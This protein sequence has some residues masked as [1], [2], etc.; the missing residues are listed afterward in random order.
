MIRKQIQ[1]AV[2]YINVIKATGS[3]F[4]PYGKVVEMSIEQSLE[5]IA[6]ATEELLALAKTQSDAPAKRGRPTK[7]KEAEVTDDILGNESAPAYTKDDVLKALR[8][9]M[10]KNGGEKTKE[11][12]I[13]HGADKAKPVLTTI[14]EKNYPALMK[15]L[16][17]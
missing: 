6:I 2:E 7:E 4:N 1:D 10:D 16:G 13:K 5:R 3:L 14:P 17:A 12:M 11:L 15:E 8:G 9:F